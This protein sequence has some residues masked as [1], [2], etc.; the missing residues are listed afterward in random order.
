MFKRTFVTG[1]TAAVVAV[2]AL[3]AA[4]QPTMAGPHKHHHHHHKHH[5]HHKHYGH[6]GWGVGGFLLGA[7]L[8]QP[9]VIVVDEYGSGH[10]QRCLARYRSYDPATDTYM[11]YDGIRRYCRL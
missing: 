11:G 2:G 5:K 3:T 9:R 1:L 10:V 8:A 7:A 6:F 4:V